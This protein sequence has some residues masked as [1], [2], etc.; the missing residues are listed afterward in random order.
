MVETTQLGAGRN[1]HLVHIGDR[2]LLVGATDHGISLLQGYDREEAT[3]EGLLEEREA[4]LDAAARGPRG[5]AAEDV[6]RVAA[7]ADD[8]IAAMARSAPMAANS[9]AR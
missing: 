2:V 9:S 8:Q 1:L 6:R 3:M 5:A 4:D 7:R